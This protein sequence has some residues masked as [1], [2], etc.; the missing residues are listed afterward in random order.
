[1]TDVAVTP[2]AMDPYGNPGG[3][4]AGEVLDP[5]WGT[6]TST[7]VVRR[8]PNTAARDNWTNPPRGALCVT[9]DTDTVWQRLGS[10]WAR[11]GAW[12]GLDCTWG[13]GTASAD[14]NIPFAAVLNRSGPEWVPGATIPIPTGLGGLYIVTIA[15]YLGGATTLNPS[16]VTMNCGGQVTYGLCTGGA[17]FSVT[18]LHMLAAA[19]TILA[20]IHFSPS[21][22]NNSY[23]R[24]TIARLA[25]FP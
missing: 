17:G 5:A 19:A 22:S 25:A 4:I 16:Y 3:V 6:A 12:V 10:A 15:G 8:F 21:P 1:M 11:L 18:G 14:A 13:P 2:L 20:Q 9:T 7:T 24:C 23:V